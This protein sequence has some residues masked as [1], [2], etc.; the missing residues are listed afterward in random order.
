LLSEGRQSGMIKVYD[1]FSGCGGASCGFKNAGMHIA[2]GLDNNPDAASTFRLNFPEANFIEEDIRNL[3]AEDLEQYID[4]GSPSLFCG[5]APCQPFSKQN[6]NK[7]GK[8]DR[9]NLLQEFGRF[10]EYYLPDF[11]FVENVPGI[12]NFSIEVSPLA[13]FCNLLKRLKYKKPIIEIVQASKYGIPQTRKRLIVM[14]SKSSNLRLPNFTHGSGLNIKYSTVGDWIRDLPPL[15]AG[16]TDCNDPEHCA[17]SLSEK[18]IKRI[19]ATPEGGG[20]LDWPEELWLE[21]HKKHVGHSDV[22]GRLSYGRPAS[23]L[24]TKCI[25]YSNGRFGHPV[26]DRAISVREAARLQTFPFNYRFQGSMMSKAKQ[27]GNAVP[28]LM[29]EKLGEKFIEIVETKTL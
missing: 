27:I 29:A 16:E 20:R 7:N 21:C 15:K 22:Y 10:V 2:L 14:A 28:P 23:A 25:S 1:F 17:A 3:K 4:K 12:Q 9:I 5:C 8:D 11:I 19:K 26:D 24:T 18:N 13:E 6:Q